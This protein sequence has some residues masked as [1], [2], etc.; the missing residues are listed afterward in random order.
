MHHKD[1]DHSACPTDIQEKQLGTKKGVPTLIIAAASIDDVAAITGFGVT[2]GFVFVG[3]GSIAWTLTKGPCEAAAGL[4]VGAV[5]GVL[6]RH[7]PNLQAG[8]DPVRL[9]LVTLSGLFV[10]FVSNAVNFGGAGP[11]AALTVCRS[12]VI[13]S[14]A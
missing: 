10:I 12:N 13:Y 4:I 11:L 7:F 8:S 2:L 1:C 14:I 6:L 3:H 5:I 9:V